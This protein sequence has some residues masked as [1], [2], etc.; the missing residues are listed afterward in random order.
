M[1]RVMNKG[2]KPRYVGSFKVKDLRLGQV[3][4]IVKNARYVHPSAMTGADLEHDA[5][6]DLDLMDRGSASQGSDVISC[7]IETKI[8]MSKTVFVPIQVTFKLVE[9]SGLLR[10]GVRKEKSFLSFL[11]NPHIKF[12]VKSEIGHSLYLKDAPFV[13]RKIVSLV[14]KAIEKKLVWP[15]VMKIKLLWPKTWHPDL[16]GV[17]DDPES[18]GKSKAEYEE[19]LKEKKEKEKKEEEKQK[20]AQKE[21]EEKNAIRESAGVGS[22]G[23]KER[24]DSLGERV[25]EDQ[26][27]QC[28]CAAIS[29]PIS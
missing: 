26:R 21:E 6:V 2:K 23:A 8:W 27:T 18:W 5:A 1:S 17:P 20:V 4:P 14:K 28:G 15:S 29:D 10:I 12:N 24:G 7:Q 11:S 16:R 25:C 3:P 9:L 19:F 22:E 13:E